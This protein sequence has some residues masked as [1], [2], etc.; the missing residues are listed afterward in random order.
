MAD[1]VSR[2]LIW[3]GVVSLL[4][5]L[6]FGWDKRAAVRAGRRIPE[7]ALLSAAL[8]GGGIGGLLGMY[9]FRHKTR[10]TLFRLSVPLFLLL[11]GAL[12]LWAYWNR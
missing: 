8:L 9:L 1:P 2:L 11:Q 10:K 12:L 3:Y 6:L 5:M 4:T 7:A